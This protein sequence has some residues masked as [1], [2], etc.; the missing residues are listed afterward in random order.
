MSNS[1]DL[2]IN[3]EII[4]KINELTE[5]LA[6]REHIDYANLD[7]SQNKSVTLQEL[8]IINQQKEEEIKVLDKAW[9]NFEEDLFGVVQMSMQEK[10]QLHMFYMNKHKTEKNR[11]AG[12]RSV[13]VWRAN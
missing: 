2:N 12:Q 10:N 9:M 5:L 11:K 3:N 1:P 13:G 7:P 4:Q 8:E 6:K